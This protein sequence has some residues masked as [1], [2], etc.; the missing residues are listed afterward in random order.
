MKRIHRKYGSIEEWVHGEWLTLQP[1]IR[2]AEE[3]GRK[4]AAEKRMGVQSCSLKSVT[5]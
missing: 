5:P 1:F 3:L 4:I 2:E